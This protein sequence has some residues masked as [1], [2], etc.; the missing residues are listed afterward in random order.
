MT[1]L[2]LVVPIYNVEKYL[3][4]CIQSLLAQ[5][6]KEIEIILVD[7]ESPDN[8]PQICDRYVAKYTYVKVVHKKNDGLGQAR[9]SGMEV[10]TG[11]YI[12]FV[13]SDDFIS[14]LMLENLYLKIIQD[15][16]DIVKCAFTRVHKD[17]S[18]TNENSK[19]INPNKEDFFKTKNVTYIFDHDSIHESIK[20][21]EEP[22]YKKILKPNEE[23]LCSQ[24]LWNKLDD[25]EKKYCVLEESYTIA[26]E[27]LL[28][29]GH[30]NDP[31][32]AFL[33]ALER[34]CTTLTKGWFRDF[35]IDNYPSII[36][37]YNNEILKSSLSKLNICL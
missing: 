34:V 5:T 28:S 8:C 29:K 30:I 21:T 33:M 36:N 16:A 18:N 6:L 12:A 20:L 27:R 19:P 15:N 1:I 14:P 4:R 17:G 2:S 22:I 9:N 10:A 25:L 3:D 7:D 11:E 26:I 35:A 32:E 23:V 31:K 37:R 24:E 13:D